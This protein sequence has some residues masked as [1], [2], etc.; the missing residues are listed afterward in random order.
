MKLK[1]YSFFLSIICLILCH[2]LVAFDV[3]PVFFEKDVRLTHTL[4]K[5]EL[6]EG[7]KLFYYRLHVDNRHR[8]RNKTYYLVCLN[9]IDNVIGS[10]PFRIDSKGEIWL[11]VEDGSELL[12]EKSFCL[13]HFWDGESISYILV[14]EYERMLARTKIY[15]KPLEAKS[16]DG[17]TI[18]LRLISGASYVFEGTGFKPQE[19][20]SFTYLTALGIA[21]PFPLQAD[22]QGVFSV[23]V[24]APFIDLP[25]GRDIVVIKRDDNTELKLPFL[26]GISKE[27]LDQKNRISKD[28]GCLQNSR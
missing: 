21:E 28:D 22:D 16:D 20:V 1:K 5:T 23:G 27:R 19:H 18:F 25:Y 10:V 17:A 13:G 15:P 24:G 26:W 14:D 7:N 3:D 6:V 2:K 8:I 11:E 12:K 9:C 4:L